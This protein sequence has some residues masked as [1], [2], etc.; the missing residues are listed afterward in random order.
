[1]LSSSHGRQQAGGCRL[2]VQGCVLTL[3][4]PVLP[5]ACLA[6]PALSK[7]LPRLSTEGE[8][9]QSQPGRQ[10][11]SSAELRQPGSR[12]YNLQLQCVWAPHARK[13]E[14]ST[15]ASASLLSCLTARQHS[16]VDSKRGSE[17]RSAPHREPMPQA[18]KFCLSR[19]SGVPLVAHVGFSRYC[20]VSGQDP[21]AFITYES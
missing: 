2:F 8:P 7:A 14:L 19:F 9:L 20:Q 3:R 12:K 17:L 16:Y 18:V 11:G 13:N 5:L 1:M 10:A 15:A 6:R 21:G 4:M